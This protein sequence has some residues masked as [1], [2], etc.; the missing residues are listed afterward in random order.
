MW[1]KYIGK[2]SVEERQR[3]SRIRAETNVLIRKGV[4]VK[5][6]CEKCGE[7]NVACH[8]RKYKD[9]TDIMWLCKSC[10]LTCH[11]NHLIQIE[12]KNILKDYKP[13]YERINGKRVC[14]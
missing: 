12:L 7:I 2:L 13:N 9:P 14:F 11:G 8:H 6:P 10:H 5:S 3:R 1:N 4:L